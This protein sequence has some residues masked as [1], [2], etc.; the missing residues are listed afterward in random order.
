M[1][2]DITLKEC[3]PVKSVEI[4]GFSLSRFCPNG[5]K[6]FTAGLSTSFRIWNP[7]NYT[8][9]KWTNLV[10]RCNSA[11]W[12]PDG[13]FLLFT[14]EDN[15]L[16]YLLKFI[17]NNKQ[18]LQVVCDL[19]SVSMFGS[20]N[21]F[22]LAENLTMDENKCSLGGAISDMCWDSHGQ[23]LAISFKKYDVESQINGV[24]VFVTKFHPQFQILPL[25]FV[26]DSENSWPSSID[27][28]PQFD[29]GA[30]LTIGWSNG[31]VQ[32]VPFNFSKLNESYPIS[33]LSYI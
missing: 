32:H 30:L 25:G 2:W 7:I 23:R 33:N 8:S 16:L 24:A 27:F 6:L 21:D 12:S 10:S 19:S 28:K 9:E 20:K 29:E 31:R 11:C 13:S 26:Y 14:C 18:E 3:V 15:S 17:N 4:N 1:I 22:T 5:T